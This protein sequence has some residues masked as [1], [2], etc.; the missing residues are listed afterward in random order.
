MLKDVRGRSGVGNLRPDVRASGSSQRDEKM[1]STAMKA[2][3]SPTTPSRITVEWT[4][5][6]T[7]IIVEG[8]DAFLA[9]TAIAVAYII[10]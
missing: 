9:Y 2:V 8:L 3:Q 6:K 1:R 7:T 4:K 10:F 5:A